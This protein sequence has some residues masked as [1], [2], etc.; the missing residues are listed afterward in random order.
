MRKWND[1]WLN[2]W[3]MIKCKNVLTKMLLNSCNKKKEFLFS[4][5]EGQN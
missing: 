5:N 1:W 2:D 3:M 4:V